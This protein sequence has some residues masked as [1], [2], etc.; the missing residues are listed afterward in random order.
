MI[1]TRGVPA[2]YGGFE[3]AIEEIGRRLVERG[4]S[5]TVYCRSAGDRDAVPSEHLGMRLVTLPALRS[6]AV[7]TISHSAL[8]AGHE[9]WHRDE[10]VTFVFNAANSVFLP[11]VHLAG[12]PAAV[13]VDGLEWRRA[14]WGGAGQRY[15]RAAESLAVRWADALIAD[16]VGIAEYYR[17]EFEATT[18]RIAY[19][20]RVLTDLAEDRLGSLELVRD[21]FHLVVARFEP[22]NHVDVIVQGY[23]DSTARLPLVVVGAAPY[24]DEYTE[25]IRV[26]AG[27]DPRIRL[28]GAVWD[29]DQLD[30]LYGH[31]R[32]YLHGHSVG[33][34]NPS[35]LRAMGAG[36]AVSAYDVIFNREVLDGQA[37]FFD[38]TSTVARSIEEAESDPARCASLAASARARIASHYRWEEVASDYERLAQRLAG[39]WSRRGECSGRRTGAPAWRDVA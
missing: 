36:A 13:H 26:V 9:L 2:R 23:H 15:Y 33:G 6:K 30:Q 5:V 19:G 25:A 11:I 17:E 3:T 10:D 29:Q 18:E 16:S 31:A 24:S 34:T 39:G 27:N 8:S 38:D 35:L 7:E 32:L 28:L 14:K 20:A 4:H 1:G 22:E 21:G 37:W 12:T